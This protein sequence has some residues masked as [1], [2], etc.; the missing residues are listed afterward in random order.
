M[1]PSSKQIT[2]IM[3]K[4]LEETEFWDLLMRDIYG[5][6][7]GGVIIAID[8]ENA[9]KGVAKTSGAVALYDRLAY[10]FG[11][12]IDTNDG[13]LSAPGVFDCYQ[14]HPGEHQPSVMVWDEAVGGG[15]G[16]A[17]RAMSNENTKLGRAWQILRTKRIVTITTLPNWGELDPRLQKLADYR[18]WCR[19]WPIGEF[20]AY[21]VNTS[22]S[23]DQV[24]T[25]GLG[26]EDETTSI[27]FPNAASD[28]GDLGE[29]D[30][31]AHPLY[32]HLTKKKAELMDT[33]DY[34]AGQ[35]HDD[36][37]DVEELSPAEVQ[38]QTERRE[39]VKTVIRACEPWHDEGVSYLKASKLVDYSR[40]WVGNRVREWRDEYEHRDL[41][42]DPTRDNDDNNKSPA[43][44]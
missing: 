35:M 34:L 4:T 18:L 7:E 44:V 8:A 2:G 25:K 24:K 9:R 21:K 31:D 29:N 43:S 14:D 16:D 22:F 15:S 30:S 17:R 23:G 27:R 6:R 19:E 40:E 39:A 41:V 20:G 37:E 5:P 36:D 32:E 38:E 12:E 26:P 33:D 3:T 10:E 42:A 1:K 11:Y 13:V 28:F